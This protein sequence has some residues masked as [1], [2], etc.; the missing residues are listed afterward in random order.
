[1]ITENFTG[2]QEQIW[3]SREV[4]RISAEEANVIQDMINKYGNETGLRIL[5]YFEKLHFIS[6]Y[7][8]S[9]G[10]NFKMNQFYYHCNL[11]DVEKQKIALALKEALRIMGE[12]TA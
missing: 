3:E 1:M 6:A 2:L 4:G 7:L 5:K 11:P 9:D 8:K 10:T 12:A